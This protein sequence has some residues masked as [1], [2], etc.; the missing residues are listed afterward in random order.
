[1]TLHVDFTSQEYFR[2]PAAAIE[3]LRAGAGRRGPVPAHR[4]GLD[5]DDARP[6][7]PG[8]AKPRFVRKDMEFGG[9][10]LKQGD[11]IMPM[12]VAGNCDPQAHEHPEKLDLERRANR[13]IAFG[14][15]A[16]FCLGHQL[17][18]LEAKCALRAL[19][20]RWPQLTLAMEDSHIHWRKRAGIRA[21]AQ[22]PVLAGRQAD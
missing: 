19:F 7:Q 17:A 12:L 4:N 8:L 15:G 2:N 13:H 6:G 5:D 22:L 10:R 1:M 14:A 20:E 11:R 3:R 16:H 21:I 18:R 9:V